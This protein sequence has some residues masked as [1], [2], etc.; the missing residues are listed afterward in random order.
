[1]IRSLRITFMRP[2]SSSSRA[3]T[4]LLARDTPLTT[5][6]AVLVAGL[7]RHTRPRKFPT[8]LTS[9]VEGKRRRHGGRV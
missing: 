1:M 6:G 8:P 4:P 3:S 5:R 9:S 7:L 2:P